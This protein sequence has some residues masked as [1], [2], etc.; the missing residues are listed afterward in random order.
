MNKVLLSIIMLMC[1]TVVGFSSYTGKIAYANNDVLTILNTLDNSTVTYTTTNYNITHVQ[2]AS[3]GDRNLILTTKAQS[4]YGGAS[5]KVFEINENGALVNQFSTNT[6]IYSCFKTASYYYCLGSSIYRFE[7]DGTLYDTTTS[8][9]VGGSSKSCASSK[10]NTISPNLDDSV[11]YTTC[12]D[13]DA[14]RWLTTRYLINNTWKATLNINLWGDDYSSMRYIPDTEEIEIAS[15]N[16]TIFY[17]GLNSDGVVNSTINSSIT[18]GIE[19]HYKALGDTDYYLTTNGTTLFISDGITTHNYSFDLG[20]MYGYLNAQRFYTDLYSV[21]FSFDDNSLILQSTLSS[22]DCPGGESVQAFCTFVESATGDTYYSMI[23]DDA[24]TISRTNIKI[25]VS[26]ATKEYQALYTNN[27]VASAKGFLRPFAPCWDITEVGATGLGGL[28]YSI[29]YSEIGT[30][31]G[32]QL[33]LRT[34]NMKQFHIFPIYNS[35]YLKGWNYLT[36]NDL[37]VL[38]AGKYATPISLALTPE[39]DS[40]TPNSVTWGYGLLGANIDNMYN[41][42]EGNNIWVD[43]K[44]YLALAYNTSD[45]M[46][47][48]STWTPSMEGWNRT[49]EYVPWATLRTR[50][51]TYGVTSASI[52][53]LLASQDFTT[54]YS[55]ISTSNNV[56]LKGYAWGEVKNTN[57]TGLYAVNEWKTPTCAQNG[58]GTSVFAYKCNSRLIDYTRWT[59]LKGE[60]SFCNVIAREKRDYILT[61]PGI[62]FYPYMNS[63]ITENAYMEDTLEIGDLGTYNYNC[64]SE[65]GETQSGAITFDAQQTLFPLFWNDVTATVGVNL[66]VVDRN[67][68]ALGTVTTTLYNTTGTRI[69]FSKLTNANGNVA[70]NYL[71]T[72]VN[73]VVN[74]KSARESINYTI[75]IGDYRNS[76]RLG[77]GTFCSAWNGYYEYKL[78]LNPILKDVVFTVKCENLRVPDAQIYIDSIF[79]G[80]T[81]SNGILS[82]ETNAD[83]TEEYFD[84]DVYSRYGNDRDRKSTRLN[85]SHIPL[86]RMPS[87]A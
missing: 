1:L 69:Q 46:I 76:E 58:Y 10:K 4:G 48:N 9:N 19:Q 75:S 87:S 38:M 49:Y 33:H 13:G 36:Q 47:I 84:V 73:Y 57:T 39:V 77:N 45:Y 32:V 42:L 65:Y 20:A 2:P 62:Q 31:E 71:D 67:N 18:S 12:T 8:Y 55:W 28:D 25:G 44:F 80:T 50:L 64:T 81:D 68:F 59:D 85:S 43:N 56:L 3:T 63:N 34:E 72:N 79:K 74:L 23:D 70:F 11:Y 35:Y 86:S 78:V 22:G 29:T 7:Y 82:F 83:R 66:T 37:P 30:I 61:T 53:E 17:L 27:S 60:A 16:T 21:G 15:T 40:Y 41:D 24:T 14:N 5:Y 54:P 51:E 6:D 52:D 26:H